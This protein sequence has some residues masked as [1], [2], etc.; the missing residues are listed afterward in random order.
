MSVERCRRLTVHLDGYELRGRTVLITGGTGSFGQAAAAALLTQGCDDI[1]IFSRDEWKQEAMRHRFADRR[2][3][4]YLGDVRDRGSVDGAMDG[5]DLVFHAAALKQVPSCEFFPMQAVATNVLGSNNVLESAAEHGVERV[6]CLS[7]DKAAY[8]VNAMGLSKALMEKAAQARARTPSSARTLV[9]TVRYGN[10]LYSRGSVV[11]LFL[12]QLRAGQPLTVTLPEMTRFLL[13]LDSAL[14]LVL[15][16]LANARSG[17]LFVRKAP[18]CTIG[19][20][21]DA[22]RV[23]FEIPAPI[24]II[25]MRHGE[26]VYETLATREEMERAEDLGDYYRIAMDDR[27]L[28]YGKY[29]EQGAG[30]AE[31]CDDYTSH[32]TTRLGRDQVIELLLA[33]PEVQRELQPSLELTAGAAV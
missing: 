13:P 25:G 15:F 4:F 30:R 1:R 6:I 12:Q 19:D 10:V 17:D 22:M 2:L 33:L 20:L 24:R 27:D 3:R 21:A 31:P 28:N 7:T 9:A 18:A 11:P 5:A 8:P 23:L 29:V 14:D 26:K 32:N 16:A